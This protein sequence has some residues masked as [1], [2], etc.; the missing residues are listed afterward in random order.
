MTKITFI[1]GFNICLL[2]IARTQFNFN[3]GQLF[4]RPPQNNN[5]NGNSGQNPRIDLGAIAGGILGGIARPRPNQNQGGNAANNILGGLIN[6]AVGAVLNN[7]DVSLGF[8]NGNLQVAVLPKQ[9]GNS[10]NG[11]TG[12]NNSDDNE[13][14]GETCV[15]NGRGRP[16]VAIRA[17]PN[18]NGDC[19][20]WERNFDYSGADL[21]IRNNP[22]QVKGAQECQKLCQATE[23]CS[24]WTW[25]RKNRRRTGRRTSQCWLKSSGF[26][27][28][29]NSER[30]SGPRNC[31]DIEI[32][33]NPSSQQSNRPTASCTTNGG[34]DSGARCVF[35]FT[36]KEKVYRGCI[37]VDADDGKPWCST[38]TDNNGQHIGGQGKW[39]HCPSSCNKDLDGS[40]VGSSSSPQT[41][42]TATTVNVEGSISNTKLSQIPW[43]PSDGKLS[44]PIGAVASN[45]IEG[46]TQ[47]DITNRFLALGL[48][49][50]NIG[51]GQCRAPGNGQGTCRHIH[52]CVKPVFFNFITFLTHMC[53]IEGRYIGVC[54]PETITTTTST[55]T[56]TPRPTAAPTS[57]SPTREC[58]V[59]AKR[60]QTRIVGGRPADPDEWPWLAALV[61]KSGRGSG[62]YCGATLISDTHVLTAAHCLAPFKREDIL[63]KLGEYDFEKEGETQDQTFTVQSMK[64]HENYNDVTYE[65]DIAIMK[66]D[67]PAILSNSVWPICLPPASERFTNRRAFVIGWGTIYFGGPVSSTLQE[68]NV[69]VWEPSEC[70]KNYATLDR[71]VLDTMLCAG[72]TNRDSCQG[73]SGGPLNCMSQTTRKWELC[74]V[75]SWGARCAEPDFPGVYTKVTE[76]LSWISNNSV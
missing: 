51:H 11:N 2:P 43:F 22:A 9:P 42:P 60:F 12:N 76:Y 74:G 18:L 35:P 70:K 27:K 53:I 55:T 29:S 15:P 47:N 39:G 61:H 69:R 23:S 34:G 41:A 17:G 24:H 5:N 56:T 20:C 32:V 26:R 48:N 64:N 73:D 4:G 30:V 10:N 19:D 37:L 72:E 62:Q 33:I 7:T 68:V 25:E 31:G 63:V 66:L 28:G 59:N 14:D 40:S 71:N 6:N 1:I 21:P 50:P 52:H 54:C 65:N 58:G 75:V 57:P 16:N 36:Y 67:R 38:L 13:D 3:L 8:E 45:N 49:K 44:L 46:V